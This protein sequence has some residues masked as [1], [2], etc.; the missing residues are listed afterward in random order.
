MMSWVF[1]CLPARIGRIA[2]SEK[3]HEGMP[4][5]NC[6]RDLAGVIPCW[7]VLVLEAWASLL[8]GGRYCYVVVVVAAAAAVDDNTD[9]S[10]RCRVGV[11]VDADAPNEYY[12][13]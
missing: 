11:G 3:I 5:E 12:L 9:D 1:G 7:L 4:P 6:S 10:C 8:R 2:A 13:Y